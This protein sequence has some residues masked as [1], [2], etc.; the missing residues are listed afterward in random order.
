[1]L[2][3]S[4]QKAVFRSAKD[5]LLARKTWPFARQNTAYWIAACRLLFLWKVKIRRKSLSV[6][7]IIYTFVHTQSVPTGAAGCDIFSEKDVYWR[8]LLQS[9]LAN[10]N[11]HRKMRQSKRPCWGILYPCLFSVLRG[12]GRQ[13]HNTA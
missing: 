13:N 1:M 10:L 8:C 6:S 4:F 5:G 2:H 9:N 11:I 7:E 3:G 12:G